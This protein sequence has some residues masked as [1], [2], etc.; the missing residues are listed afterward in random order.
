MTTADS[1]ECI[2]GGGVGA[3]RLKGRVYSTQGVLH[4]PAGQPECWLFIDGGKGSC[5]KPND[6]RADFGH[7]L[8][9][10]SVLEADRV[11]PAHYGKCGAALNEGVVEGEQDVFSPWPSSPG[12]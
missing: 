6:L 3:Q 2:G 9:A 8:Q 10:V 4:D 5:W 7:T 1:S 12:M 11:V